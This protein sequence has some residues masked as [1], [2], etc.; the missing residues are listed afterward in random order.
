M[1]SRFRTFYYKSRLHCSDSISVYLLNARLN[2]LL[3][4]SIT[5]DLIPHYCYI[6]SD[7]VINVI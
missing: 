2:S 1:R 3:S 4:M 5:R 7:I 6:I